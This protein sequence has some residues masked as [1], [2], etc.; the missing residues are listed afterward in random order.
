MSGTWYYILVAFQLLYWVEIL[1]PLL[2]VIIDGARLVVLLV[3]PGNFDI[4]GICARYIHCFKM[5]ICIARSEE[6]RVGK[7]CSW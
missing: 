7:E 2:R 5:H 1:C 3:L 6:R 4:L